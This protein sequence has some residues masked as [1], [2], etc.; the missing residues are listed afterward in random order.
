[1]KNK[2]AVVVLF[3]FFVG[4][5]FL[6]IPRA[7]EGST[8]FFREYYYLD[9]HFD[10]EKRPVICL[11]P[12]IYQRFW[13]PLTIPVC[14][15]RLKLYKIELTTIS[16]APHYYYF[17]SE[18]EPEICVKTKYLMLYIH[19]PICPEGKD[20]YP[21]WLTDAQRKELWDEYGRIM[22]LHEL[23]YGIKKKQPPSPLYE[24]LYYEK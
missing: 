11:D 14:P 22:S 17:N 23:F 19:Y 6:V 3:W 18:E 15:E 21:L 7:S 12:Y 20:L 5:L 16:Q 10:Q 2:I 4:F 24:D 13:F 8:A 9:Q 1:M